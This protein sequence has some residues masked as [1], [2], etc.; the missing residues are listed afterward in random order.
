MSCGW[1]NA[2]RDLEEQGYIALEGGLRDAAGIAFEQ[3]RT[4]DE[5]ALRLLA[6]LCSMTLSVSDAKVPFGPECVI[7]G[8]RSRIPE[9]L[10]AAEIAGLSEIVPQVENPW[11][12]GRLAHVVWI[13]SQPR[14]V[15]FALMTIDC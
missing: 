14:D 9:D 8:R 6:E 7:E 10:P 5:R 3:E 4:T 12:K 15:R 13:A 2:L 1:E 11:L